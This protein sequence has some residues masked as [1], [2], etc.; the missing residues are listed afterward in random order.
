V[1]GLQSYAL[2]DSDEN[3]LSLGALYLGLEARF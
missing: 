2:E 3:E 1:V